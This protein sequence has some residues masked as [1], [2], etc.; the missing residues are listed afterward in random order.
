MSGT[1]MRRWIAAT[2]LLLAFAGCDVMGDEDEDASRQPGS[3]AGGSRPKPVDGTF[4]GKL[5]GTEAFVAVAAAPVA[6]GRRRREITVFACGDEEVCEWLTGSAA[7]NRF[8]AASSD[9]DAE[10]QGSLTR[11]A[12]SG[13]IELAGGETSDVTA[14][15]ATAAAGLYTLT[16]SPGGRLQGASAGGVGLTGR[17]T[18]PEPGRGTLRLADGTRLRFLATRSTGAEALRI[19]RGEARLIVLPDGELRGAGPN[20]YLRSRR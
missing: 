13:S 19:R 6:Q 17:S 15:R 8:S 1:E 4:V 9:G 14:R 11:R 2:V 18:L 5:D 3:Q 7:G 10:F 12:A 16:V 20:F